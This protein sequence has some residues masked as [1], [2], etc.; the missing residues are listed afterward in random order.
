MYFRLRGE[1]P[2]TPGNR[3]L[4]S[5]DSRSMTL[6]PDRPVAREHLSVR[7]GD[8]TSVAGGDVCGDAV[9]QVWVPVGEGGSGRGALEARLV[10]HGSNGFV[11]TPRKPR[12]F[13]GH[14]GATW[15]RFVPAAAKMGG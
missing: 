15:G 2:A 3:V 14:L 7:G 4:R 13:A 6:L 11:P 10:V 1:Y 9:E 8:R 5:V 12:A